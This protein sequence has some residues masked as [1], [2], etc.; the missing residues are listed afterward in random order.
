MVFGKTN[1]E[2]KVGSFVFFGLAILVIF[3]LSIGGFKT[4][5]S[6][7]TIDLAFNFVN[8]I[9]LGSPVRFAGVDVGRVTKIAV[10]TNP[11]AKNKVRI[12]AW[13]KSEIS[14]PA[15]SPIEI[16]TLGLLGEKY[17][18]IMPGKGAST[19]VAQHQVLI[20]H[21]PMA[22]HEVLNTFRDITNEL[23]AILLKIKKGE[24]SVGKFIVDD[25]L[26]NEVD[27][28]VKDIRKNPWKLIWKTKEKK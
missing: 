10:D 7:Y 17:I 22:L 1:L 8:G 12:T 20:G 3:V 9:K 6:G 25:S 24:G 15:D 11:G 28:L 2:L 26:Y 14:I 4:W 27:G 21:D 19:Y 23:D 5:T 16:N 13:I 18:E